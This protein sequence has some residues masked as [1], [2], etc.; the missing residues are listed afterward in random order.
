MAKTERITGAYNLSATGGITLASDTTVG[1]NL[2]ITGTTT[3]I[4][5]TQTEIKDRVIVLNDGESGAGVTGRYSGLEIDRGSSDNAFIVFDENDD[6]F[7]IST[8]NGSSYNTILTGVGAGL[9]AVLQDTTP[10]LGGDLDINSFNIVSAQS[11]E[12]IQLVPNG[13]GRVTVAS[14]L[15]LNDLASAPTGATGA[16]LLYADTAAGG[17]TGVYFVD[18]ST[19]DELVSKSKAIVYGLI[20]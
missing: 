10:Q 3:T 11:N 18:G 9:T 5:A 19:S 8:D 16:T 20:F 14:A 2:T 4:S 13:T 17:G 15:K 7:K 12:D 6:A 1:G